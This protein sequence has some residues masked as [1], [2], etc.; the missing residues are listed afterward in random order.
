MVSIFIV[1]L[2][3]NKKARTAYGFYERFHVDLVRHERRSVHAAPMKAPIVSAEKLG[4]RSLGRGALSPNLGGKRRNCAV[5]IF[6]TR[7]KDVAGKNYFY[8][9]SGNTAGSC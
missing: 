8:Q 7:F 9:D 2:N 5:R 3:E 1:I 6:E 4:T